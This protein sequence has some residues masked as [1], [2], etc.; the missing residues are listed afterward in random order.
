MNS[1]P[2]ETE[3]NEAYAIELA[4]YALYQAACQWANKTPDQ[5]LNIVMFGFN[6]LDRYL[7]K[8]WDNHSAD[9]YHRIGVQDRRDLRI[10]WIKR[11]QRRIIFAKA[12]I[13]AIYDHLCRT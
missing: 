7:L 8:V 9:F 5:Y 6:D 4:S 3:V 12:L 11:I 2:S 13:N 1:L 10:L